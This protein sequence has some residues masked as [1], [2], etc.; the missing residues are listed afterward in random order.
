MWGT[1]PEVPQGQAALT[2][3]G[4]TQ[5]TGAGFGVEQVPLGNP[6]ILPGDPTET[7][8]ES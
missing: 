5:P 4:Q 6:S 7:T 8:A 2:H 1:G 3:R